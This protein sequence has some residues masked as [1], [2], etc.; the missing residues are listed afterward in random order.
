MR[1][2]RRICSHGGDHTG[3]P[4]WGEGA[5][6]HQRIGSGAGGG[7]STEDLSSNLYFKRALWHESGGC[8][9]CFDELHPK[10]FSSSPEL[11]SDWN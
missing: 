4:I 5:G 8:G 1:A 3:A 6:A 11:T 10:M 2:H 9:T 7:G